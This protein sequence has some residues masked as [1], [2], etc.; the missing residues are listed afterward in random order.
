VGAY[1][2]HP[3]KQPGPITD[4]FSAARVVPAHLGLKGKTACGI[5]GGGRDADIHRPP[6]P[7]HIE[8]FHSSSIT[9]DETEGIGILNN[10]ILFRG[11]PNRL[12]H[13]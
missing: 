6:A 8:F 3:R 10:S 1:G 11:I 12:L 13:N 5:E 7:G 9:L 2:D 4:A